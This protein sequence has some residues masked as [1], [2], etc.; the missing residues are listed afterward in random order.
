MS[1]LQTLYLQAVALHRSGQLGLAEELYEKV[2]AAAPHHAETL[3]MLGAIALARKDYLHAALLI[4]SALE[5]G[6]VRAGT[7][8]NLGVAL[9]GLGQLQ[10]ALA[11]YDHAIA[12]QADYAEAHYNRGIVLHALNRYEE[13]LAATDRAIDLQPGYALAHNNRGAVMNDLNRLA[14][15]MSSYAQAAHL[16]PQD[17]LARW[18][19]ALVHLKAG[20]L[21]EGWRLYEYGWL[22]DKRGKPRPWS[23]PLWLGDTS[24][25]GKTILLHAEQG[26]GDTLQFM[27]YIQKVR[28]AGALKIFLE[29]PTPLIRFFQGQCPVDLLLPPGAPCPDFDLHCPLLSLPLA[30]QTDLANIPVASPYLHSSPSHVQ[31]WSTRL[32]PYKRPRVG[33]AWSGNPIHQNDHNR[34]LPLAELLKYLPQGLDYISLQKDVRA[35]DIEALAQARDLRHFGSEIEDFSDTAALCDLVDVIVSVDTS[36]AHLAGAMHRPTWILL[37]FSGDWRWLTDRQDSPW[38]PSV[39]L[40][41]QDPSRTWEGALRVLR[42]QLQSLTHRLIQQ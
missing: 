36:V 24:L 22:C 15:S 18:N 17:P 13:A 34:S 25:Q 21:L 8:C 32:G 1:A 31:H 37:P 26:L 4:R 5:I 28:T 6:P 27:R 30:F 19:L 23:Q 20:N 16:A 29:V 38:Y 3:H 35:I 2:R 14:E 33:L 7:I 39:Q 40:I 9:K 41:R 10:E 11:H 12:M 42:T